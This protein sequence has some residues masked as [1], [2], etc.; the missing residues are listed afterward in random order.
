MGENIEPAETQDT[1]SVDFTGKAAEYLE[2]QMGDSFKR[3][4]DQEENVI[5]SLP[6]FATSIGVLVTFVTLV[7]RD[8]P[9]FDW[10][11]WPTVIYG[12][13]TG[14]LLSLLFVLLFLY[15]AVRR[16]N[17]EYLMPE[18]KMLEYARE[19]ITYY[20]TVSAQDSPTATAKATSPGDETDPVA[21]LETA[22]VSDIRNT[23][24]NDLAAA[25][26]SSR[27]NNLA[28]LTAR[29]RAFTV[30]TMALVFALGMIVAILVHDAVNGVFHGG[31][32]GNSSR[33]VKESPRAGPEDG[34][35][36]AETDS[37]GNAGGR[38]GGLELQGSHRQKGDP[39]RAE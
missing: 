4:L 15:Q 3:E 7:R 23:M 30:L 20:R 29:T 8:L 25:A 12:L 2:K 5:R 22:V 36:P 21:V 10:A 17:F 9:N 34:P 24:I 6:F 39:A 16:R 26:E 27:S 11:L 31:Q 19:V 18:T 33:G 28:R 14:V 32:D 35:L 1:Q 13:L 37:T 38:E